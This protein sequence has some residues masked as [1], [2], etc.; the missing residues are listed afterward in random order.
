[1][2]YND[3]NITINQYYF[4]DYLLAAFAAFLASSA[5]LF[6]SSLR[7]I[8]SISILDRKGVVSKGYVSASN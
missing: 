7:S 6:S 5:N 4:V 2:N 1:M 3:F 8:T